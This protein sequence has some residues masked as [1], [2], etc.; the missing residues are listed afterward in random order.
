MHESVWQRGEATVRPLPLSAITPASQSPAWQL[1]KPRPIQQ[2]GQS[3]L[4][5]PVW[6]ARIKEFGKIKIKNIYIIISPLLYF[7]TSIFVLHLVIFF[8]ILFSFFDSWQLICERMQHISKNTSTQRADSNLHF[9]SLFTTCW[10]SKYP[11]AKIESLF[12]VSHLF[13]KMSPRK[14][15]IVNPQT[16]QKKKKS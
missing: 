6:V 8:F 13:L 16:M 2:V 3:A 10:Y 5:C 1:I 7:K 15:V 9:F 11:K 4:R 14:T 12:T